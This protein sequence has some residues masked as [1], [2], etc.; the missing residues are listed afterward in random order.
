MEWGKSWKPSRALTVPTTDTS[1]QTSRYKKIWPLANQSNSNCA[2]YNSKGCRVCS[3][4]IHISAKKDSLTGLWP[5]YQFRKKGITGNKV[6][7]KK[8]LMSISKRKIS[9][10]LSNTACSWFY[11]QGQ[12]SIFLFTC[13]MALLS[14]FMWLSKRGKWEKKKSWKRLFSSG[15]GDSMKMTPMAIFFFR[16]TPRLGPPLSSDMLKLSSTDLIKTRHQGSQLQQTSY[17][18]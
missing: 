3:W 1:K 13:S 15:L 18:I 14:L 7:F 16:A 9:K 2:N 12:T 10:N 8:K 5:Q 6:N 11:D 4:T 17:N